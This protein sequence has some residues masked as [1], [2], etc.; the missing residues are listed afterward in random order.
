MILAFTKNCTQQA[1]NSI[2]LRENQPKKQNNALI[3]VIL[4]IKQNILRF[5]HRLSNI[6]C[7][8]HKTCSTLTINITAAVD[9]NL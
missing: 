3:F 9:G 7:M 5:T 1:L 2:K 6:I 4:K 8:L